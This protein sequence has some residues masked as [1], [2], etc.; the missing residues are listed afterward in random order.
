MPINDLGPAHVS[1]RQ[2]L[3]SLAATTMGSAVLQAAPKRTTMGLAADMLPSRRGIQTLEI[4]QL[5]QDWG[6]GGVQCALTFNDTAGARQVRARLEELG[7]FLVATV[8]ISDTERFRKLASLAKEAGAVALRVA[9]GGRR[10]E[11]FQNLEA[12]QAHVKAVHES[13]RAA[14]PI[15]ESHKLPIALENHKDFTAEEQVNLYRGYPSE[16]FGACVDAGNNLALLEDPME[17]LERLAPYA[18]M[19]HLKDATLEEYSD[20][21]LLGDIPLGEGMLDLPRVMRTL[22]ER[23]PSLPVVLE[24]ITRNPLKIPCLTDGYWASFPQRD[25][26]ALARTM[27]LVRDN[28]PKWQMRVPE[29]ISREELRAMETK[30][31]ERCIAYARD[32]LGL[33]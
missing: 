22:H 21:F 10:Y 28:P 3:A 12:R 9:S 6:M 14:I 4:I 25:E 30:H 29:G 31:V 26:K 1:R 8:P 16:Y 23:R 24:C 2:V 13:L 5:C 32:P 19:T 7:I 27:K 17:T 33:V 20:G 15:A 18:V 11:Q